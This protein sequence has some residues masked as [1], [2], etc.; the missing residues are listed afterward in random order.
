[1]IY[2]GFDVQ[3]KVKQ[4]VTAKDMTKVYG[5]ENQSIIRS[6]LYSAEIRQGHINSGN[7]VQTGNNPPVSRNPV[8]ANN[9]RPVQMG[10]NPPVSKNPVTA[11]NGR[12]VQTGNNP[13]IN[14]KPKIIRKRAVSDGVKLISGQKW[15]IPPMN[16][17]KIGIGWDCANTAC[18]ID[19]SAFM[20][21]QNGKVPDDSWF[22]FY[23]Q[24]KSPDK[25][26]SYKSNSEN[27]YSPDDAEMTVKL[28]SVS[29][30]INKITIC[31]TI[32]EALQKRLDFSIV[33]NFYIRLM[34]TAGKELAIYHVDNISKGIISL[35]AGEIYRYKNTWKFCSV[36]NGYRKELSEF[37]SIYGVEIE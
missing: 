33:N 15:N 19:V 24:D 17:L 21:T 28:D 31:V 6:P 10:N 11:N 8:T 9:G 7:P 26:V 3:N 4:A 14:S 5:R 1:M 25:S 35:V 13:P 30:N 37:C 29:N 22:V 34:D 2:L 12:P 32:Y 27:N 16:A 18:E 36:G 20:L 23:G